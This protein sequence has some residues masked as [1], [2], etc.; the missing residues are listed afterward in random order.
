MM[1]KQLPVL[2]IL[3]CLAVFADDSDVTNIEFNERWKNFVHIF[4]HKNIS[5][6]YKTLKPLKPQRHLKPLKP[7]K[8]LKSSKPHMY[9]Q[10]KFLAKTK[11]LKLISN[12]SMV[13]SGTY[14]NPF[15]GLFTHSGAWGGLRSLILT[16]N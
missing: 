11:C 5:V 14:Y 7:L 2:L 10:K 16:K 12:H 3:W 13:V 6:D 15:Q 4:F 1:L 9:I 8:P